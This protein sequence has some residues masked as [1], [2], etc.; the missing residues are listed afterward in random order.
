MRPAPVNR[1][2]RSSMPLAEMFSGALGDAP[3]SIGSNSALTYRISADAGNIRRIYEGVR[4]ALGLTQRK[5]TPLKFATG[6][7]RDRT[8]Q[9]VHWVEHE[10]Y[11]R[12]NTVTQ[13]ILNVRKFL[14]MLEELERELNFD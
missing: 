12:E 8:Q 7:I 4:Q 14:P 10:L 3:K 13:D 9:M 6:E 1:T 11:L 5:T 2:C